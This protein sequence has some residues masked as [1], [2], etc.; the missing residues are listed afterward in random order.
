MQDAGTTCA[1]CGAFGRLRCAG[2]ARSFCADHV[3]RR[4]A[5]GYVYFCVE[6]LAREA[7]KQMPKRGRTAQG[8]GDLRRAT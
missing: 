6:C 1:E 4:F 5:M 8:A 7:A 2:C 3:E